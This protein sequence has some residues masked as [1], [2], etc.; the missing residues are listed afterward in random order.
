MKKLSDIILELNKWVKLGEPESIE[1][2]KGM[3]G[4]YEI[5]IS[6]DGIEYST[7]EIN[8]TVWPITKMD[9]GVNKTLY[10]L[11]IKLPEELKHQGIGYQ[12]YKDFLM[13]YG[14]IISIHDYRQ[15]NNEIIK[16]YKKLS[17]EDGVNI[18]DDENCIFVCTDDWVDETG[19][20]LNLDL[21]SET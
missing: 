11:D 8:L 3:E 13:E 10:R 5:P 18:I 4:A 14:N 15:N 9:H 1:G 7:N 21:F 16:I 19:Q 20:E 17:Q 12:I 2:V 6:I